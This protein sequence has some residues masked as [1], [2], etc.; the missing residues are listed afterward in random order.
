MGTAEEEVAMTMRT[1]SSINWMKNGMTRSTR[2]GVCMDNGVW[3][4]F[5][6]FRIDQTPEDFVHVMAHGLGKGTITGCR[7]ICDFG[8]SIGY[9][10]T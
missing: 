4:T 8:R 5:T 3:D 7:H 6:G 9:Q 10:T 1:D 2:Y